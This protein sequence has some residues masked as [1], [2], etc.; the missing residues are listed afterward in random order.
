[1]YCQTSQLDPKSSNAVHIPLTK[2]QKEMIEEFI[3]GDRQAFGSHN[4]PIIYKSKV[5]V[6]RETARYTVDCLMMDDCASLDRDYID[7][8]YC[9]TWGEVEAKRTV[10]R[11]RMKALATK[12]QK[13]MK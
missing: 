8:D 12:I 9:L 13:C 2:A 3:N 11:K 10:I 7:P 6:T 1:M 4:E 5:V